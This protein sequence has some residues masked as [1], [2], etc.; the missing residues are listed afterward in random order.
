VTLSAGETTSASYSAKIPRRA[1][2]GAYRL[3]GRV[4]NAADSFDEDQVVYQVN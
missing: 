1:P 4:E 2:L 3:I